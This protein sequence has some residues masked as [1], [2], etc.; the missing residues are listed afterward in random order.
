MGVSCAAAAPRGKE[1]RGARGTG[2]RAARGRGG[3]GVA[4]AASRP[5]AQ[6]SRP[7]SLELARCALP[8]ARGDTECVVRIDATYAVAL[9]AEGASLAAAVVAA[10][11]PRGGGERAAAAARAAA[12]CAADPS[13]RAAAVV[14]WAEQASRG[15]L[16]AA[17]PPERGDEDA[18]APA[19]WAGSAGAPSGSGSGSAAP[20]E[21]RALLRAAPYVAVWAA[22]VGGILAAA[23]AQIATRASAAASP[24]L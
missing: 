12:A 4:A 3:G 11:L 23:H 5:R 17:A 6:A 9:A 20:R 10:V 2:G 15:W 1:A 21:T 16:R 14:A 19:G 24:A 22:L 7:T 18:A 8:L 13:S